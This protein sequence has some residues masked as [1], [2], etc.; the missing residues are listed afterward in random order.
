MKAR[1]SWAVT[2]SSPR[3]IAPIKASR[4]RVGLGAKKPL[5]LREDLLYGV[6]MRAVGWQ[7]E[8]LPAAR[9]DDLPHPTARPPFCAQRLSITPRDLAAA[10]SV[11]PRT[12]SRYLSKTSRL[13]VASS[14][15]KHARRP[16]SV[17][18]ASSVR[19]SAQLRGVLPKALWPLWA[20]MPRRWEPARRWRPSPPRR[21]EPICVEL[22]GE[23][24]G[25]PSGPKELLARALPL[26]AIFL[27]AEAQT[28]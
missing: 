1:A 24:G 14:S 7:V 15:A 18:L 3:P 8:D 21:P 11:G 10:H 23:Q 6:E 4:V 2:A 22:P 20:T 5:D 26:P 25:L 27:S 17:M 28:P 13:V 19:F 16:S 12:R 9:L